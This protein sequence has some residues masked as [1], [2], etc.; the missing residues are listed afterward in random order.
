MSPDSFLQKL[1]EIIRLV[2]VPMVII[3]FVVAL[4]QVA[5]SVFVGGHD[6]RALFSTVLGLMILAALIFY[7]DQLVTWIS[8]FVA[9]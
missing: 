3:I 7:T 6:K 2:K 4:L 1:V 5:S 9:R 8:H